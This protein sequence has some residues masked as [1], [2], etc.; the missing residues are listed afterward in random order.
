MKHL[1]IAS[2]AAI[3]L[4]SC[5]SANSENEV[6]QEIT[7]AYINF[8]DSTF[9]VENALTAAALVQEFENTGDTLYRTVAG[10]ITKVCTVKGCWMATAIDSSSTLFVDYDYEFLLPTNSQGQNMIMTGFAYWDS[11]S[12]AELQHYAEDRGASEEEIAAISEPTGE[13]KFKAT[14]VK[15]IIPSE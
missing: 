7:Q 13:V 9:K 1:L 15:I 6:S 2:L 8:G 10:E 14:G 12:V 11:T 3:S 4:I 5:Q